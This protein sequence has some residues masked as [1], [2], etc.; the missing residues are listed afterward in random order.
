MGNEELFSGLAGIYAGG[1]PQYPRRLFE[2][3]AGLGVL[4]SDCTAADIGAGTGIFTR[5]LA[6]WVK[7]VYAVEPN[8][9]MLEQAEKSGGENIVFISGSAEATGLPS[10]SV[11]LISAAQSF[12]WFDRKKFRTECRRLL[13]PGGRVLLIWNDRNENSG[14]VCDNLRLNRE[15]CRDFR[16]FSNGVRP[17]EED[18]SDFFEGGWMAVE[19]KNSVYYDRE[20]F[21]SRSLSSSYAPRP[22]DRNRDRYIDGL[23]EIFWKYSLDGRVEYPYTARA[24]VGRVQL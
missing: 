22:G 13:S 18:F 17:G 24:F 5:Q 3:M 16:G 10:S 1:R 21:I 8:S 12:H 19:Y 7:K 11:Q 6:E 15:L 20:S 2:D 4:G 14:I 23:S 9:G